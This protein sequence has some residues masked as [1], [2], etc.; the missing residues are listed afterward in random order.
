[1][2]LRTHP[3]KARLAAIAWIAAAALY[4]AGMALGAPT[5]TFQGKAMPNNI[6]ST[7]K[8]ENCASATTNDILSDVCSD[9]IF[10]SNQLATDTTTFNFISPS[11][12]NGPLPTNH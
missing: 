1:M 12:F 5:I 3:R 9:T 2:D 6:L 8:T 4:P 10:L 11:T 7:Y